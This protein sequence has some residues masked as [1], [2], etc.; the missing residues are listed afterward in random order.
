MVGQLSAI[1]SAIDAEK[2]RT[3]PDLLKIGGW[4]EKFAVIASELAELEVN[5]WR[6]QNPWWK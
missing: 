3:Q 5:Q 4:Q 1:R 2:Q 6:V